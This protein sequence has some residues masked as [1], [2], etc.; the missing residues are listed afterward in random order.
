MSELNEKGSIPPVTEAPTEGIHVGEIKKLEVPSEDFT[1]DTPGGSDVDFTSQTKPPIRKPEQFELFAILPALALLTRLL[2]VKSGPGGIETSYFYVAP[3]L[4]GPVFAGIRDVQVIPWW[5]FR[6][7][8]FY[9]WVINYNPDGTWF[10]SL[11]PLLEQSTDFYEG[12]AFT[13]ETGRE[14]GRYLVRKHKAPSKFPA[15]PG[16]PTQQMLGQALGPKG[17]IL[18]VDHPVYQRLTEG[19]VVL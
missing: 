8:R 4:R 1:A 9:L 13:V 5:S 12:A 18:S 14:R 3:S 16:R 7:K 10:G 2:A 11:Q 15:D 19:E 17:F 6:D